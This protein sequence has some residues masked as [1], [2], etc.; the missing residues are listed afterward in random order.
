MRFGGVAYNIEQVE[1]IGSPGL[2]FAKVK[3]STEKGL[4]SQPDELLRVAKKWNL[5]LLIHAPLEENPFNLQ[6]LE[7]IS[8]GDYPPI[9]C[10][11]GFISTDF[12]HPFLDGA[13]FYS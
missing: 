5:T 7:K 12:Y 10:L 3:L 1:M 8:K 6:Y 11:E 13:T 4:I 2:D 9:R